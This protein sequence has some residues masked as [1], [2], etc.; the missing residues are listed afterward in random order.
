MVDALQ[1]LSQH[2]CFGGVQSF[3]RH[4]SGSIGLPM[5]FSVFTP[6]QIH[7]GPVPTLFYLAGLTCTEETFAIKSG[8]QRVA[9]ELG[10]M[11]IAP[12]TSPR[13][14]GIA[15][16]ARDGEFGAGAGFYLNASQT[17][18]SLHFRMEDYIVHELRR[19]A[20]TQLGADAGRLGL[21]G[22]SMGGHGALVLALRHPGL[23]KSL[24][25]LAPMVAA[26][27]CPWGTR[28][29]SG[30][31]GTD[32]SAWQGYD[33]CA[34]MGQA[35]TPYPAGILIDQGLDDRFLTEQLKPEL[36][37]AVCAYAQQ[38]LTLRRH[39]GFDHGYYF[40]QSF[41][42]DHLRFHHTRLQA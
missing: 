2:A 35:R 7:A 18:W 4:S 16:E 19:I 15:D 10:L 17:P 13:N 11:L 37:E 31:L 8:A 6:P 3:Y 22:H 28:A 9:A 41:M 21:F 20:V 1:V 40:V 12:D 33:A 26:T 27:Q 5:R 23:F 34:L 14:T 36:F 24:S 42:E 29:L 30:Y 39:R 25:A 38:P 32:P